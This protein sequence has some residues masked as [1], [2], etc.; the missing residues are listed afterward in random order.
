MDERTGWK[1]DGRSDEKSDERS[2]EKSD[3]KL[4]AAIGPKRW[5]PPENISVVWYLVLCGG[6]SREQQFSELG[7]LSCVVRGLTNATHPHT[8]GAYFFNPFQI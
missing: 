5:E 2:D 6:A 3:D 1:S 4:D 8:I 7:A